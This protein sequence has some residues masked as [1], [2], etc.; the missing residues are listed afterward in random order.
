MVNSALLLK[1]KHKPH[2]LAN[3]AFPS[4]KA[5]SSRFSLPM[6]ANA[7]AKMEEQDP[8]IANALHKRIVQ[9]IADRLTENNNTLA[10]LMD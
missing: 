5:A 10:A 2:L 7:I 1:R 4:K 8:D 6:S 3:S 9:L